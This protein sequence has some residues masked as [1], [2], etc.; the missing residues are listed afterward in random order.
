MEEKPVPKINIQ[1]IKEYFER[2]DVFLWNLET[3]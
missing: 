3:D 2:N 1:K